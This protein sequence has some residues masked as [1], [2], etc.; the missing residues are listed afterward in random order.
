MY[1]IIQM[2][3]DEYTDWLKKSFVKERIIKTHLNDD[4]ICFNSSEIYWEVRNC[5]EKYNRLQQLLNDSDELKK[6][7]SNLA[8]LKGILEKL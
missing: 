8:N 1:Y 6:L 4:I 2:T 5:I 7:K 3:P